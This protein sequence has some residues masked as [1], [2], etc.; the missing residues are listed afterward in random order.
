MLQGL[1]RQDSEYHNSINAGN[2]NGVCSF[3]SISVFTAWCLIEHPRTTLT[4]ALLCRQQTLIVTLWIFPDIQSLFCNKY[5]YSFRL[6]L[7]NQLIKFHRIHCTTAYY[8]CICKITKYGDVVRGGYVTS[9]TISYNMAT[10]RNV[11]WQTKCM[12]FYNKIN[13]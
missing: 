10:A 2:R 12:K 1:K 9:F 3:T 7:S 5:V 13:H 8:L 11:L 4:F 6:T